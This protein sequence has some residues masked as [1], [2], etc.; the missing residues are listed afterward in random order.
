[1]NID[2]RFDGVD[3][4]IDLLREALEKKIEALDQKIGKL[5]AKNDQRF[6]WTVGG[7][8]TAWVT[9][10]GTIVASIYVHH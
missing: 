3:R 6:M 5:D 2:P 10:I 9:T 4:K 7:V 1:M 8:F